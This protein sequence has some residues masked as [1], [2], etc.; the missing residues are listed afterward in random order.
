M[1]QPIIFFL[2]LITV[3]SGFVLLATN[4]NSPPEK[5]N[6]VIV[7][8]PIDECFDS[9]M[10]TWFV[11]FNENQKGGATMSEADNKASQLALASFSDCE[12]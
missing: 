1:K 8:N 12:E 6:D 3:I 9:S 7:S 2:I 11:E 10:E 4:F 5:L